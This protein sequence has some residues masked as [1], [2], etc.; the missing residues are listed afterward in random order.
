[1]NHTYIPG[2]GDEA[3]WGP[4]LGH[5]NDPRT[6]SE[7]D[8]GLEDLGKDELI[9]LVREHCDT[10]DRLIAGLR[11]PALNHG[12]V[13][14]EIGKSFAD[15]LAGSST[16]EVSRIMAE[17]QYV[18]ALYQQDWFWQLRLGADWLIGKASYERLVETRRR[19]DRNN[20]L[21][22]A[23]CPPDHRIPVSQRVNQGA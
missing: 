6:D 2:P 23:H 21:W 7:P 3:T 9:E 15:S 11:N 17:W 18:A 1:M 10:I 20:A 5:P 12:C 4:C 8:D 19:L 14:P 16:R 22:N 13:P